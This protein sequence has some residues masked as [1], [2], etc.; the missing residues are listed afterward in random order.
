[1]TI[2]ISGKSWLIARRAC[3]I[4]IFLLFYS[5]VPAQN[6]QHKTYNF[7]SKNQSLAKVLD[8]LSDMAGVRFAYNAADNSFSKVIDYNAENKT[9]GRIL[10]EILEL[11][12]HKYTQIGNQL[13]IYSPEFPP[14][15]VKPVTQET[16]PV[17]NDQPLQKIATVYRDVP[18]FL[19]DTL[20]LKDTVVLKPDTIVIYDTI[21]KLVHRK[22]PAFTNFSDFFRFDPDRGEGLF[23][24]LTYGQHYGGLTNSETGGE[25]QLLIDKLKKAESAGIRNFSFGADLGYSAERWTFSL[26][27]QFKGFASK[28]K[29]NYLKTTGGYFRNDTLTWYYNIHEGDTTWFP[30]TDS[31]YLPLNKSEVRYNQLNRAGFIDIQAG[32]GYTWFAWSNLKMFVRGNIGYSFLIYQN[33]I[34]LQNKEG[35]PG[36]DYDKLSLK[37]SMFNWQLGT[38]IS[39]MATN[40]IDLVGELVYQNYS[41]PFFNEYPVDRRYYSIG[42]KLGILYFF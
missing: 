19:R 23:M 13:V 39:Y 25:N 38:G 32:L 29:Y 5:I 35:F 1:M 10:S 16:S 37:R 27:T 28:F 4:F 18:V 30:V 9:F 12:G 22:R 21:E 31:V 11:S 3:I 17:E 40:N 15:G 41:A 2:Y 14:P 7:Q 36:E 34:L 26:G 8:R 20:L 33:G 6:V 42:F 24:A